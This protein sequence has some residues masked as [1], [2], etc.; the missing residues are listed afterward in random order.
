[1][2]FKERCPDCGGNGWIPANN[3][4][5]GRVVV[6]Q[7][8]RPPRGPITRDERLLIEGRRKREQQF[9]KYM[10]QKFYAFFV[11]RP[12]E[13]LKAAFGSKEYNINWKH[14]GSIIWWGAFIVA[15]FL[16]Y[17]NPEIVLILGFFVIAVLVYYG[18]KSRM[19]LD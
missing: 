12:V 3:P 16:V 14:Y 10:L 13:I 9:D 15:F 8:P 17:P 2:G 19:E 6:I 5:G 1:M 4:G 7:P 18:V 11:G